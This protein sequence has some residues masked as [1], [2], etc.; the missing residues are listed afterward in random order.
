[1]RN[2]IESPTKKITYLNL[3]RLKRKLGPD[4]TLAGP[5]IPSELDYPFAPIK[6]I[7]KRSSAVSHRGM[8]FPREKG[9]KPTLKI[10]K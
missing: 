5:Q 2:D 7:P 8:F 10:I 4:F 3:E 6:R 9:R 1:M